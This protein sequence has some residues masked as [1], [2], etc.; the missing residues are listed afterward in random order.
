MDFSQLIKKRRA[1]HSFIPDKEIPKEDLIKIIEETSL[2]PSGY[3]A[4][5]WEFILITKKNNIKAIEEIS[6]SQKHIGQAS[7]IAIVLA[8]TEIGRNVDKILADWL[9]YGYCTPEEI[10]AYKNSIAK[11]RKAEK[12][13]IMALRNA[14]LAAMSFIYSAENLGYA[15]C[16][17]M[18]FSQHQLEE[19]LEIPPDRLIALMIAIGYNDTSKEKA[20]LPRKETDELIHWEKFT[21]K[22]NSPDK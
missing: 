8:D 19:H 13:A 4:Q 16:P 9:E 1:C 10:P 7:A 18:G 6:F 15:T 12:K 3:N 5:P 21:S 17:V 14:M 11:N 2:T 20:R 22:R